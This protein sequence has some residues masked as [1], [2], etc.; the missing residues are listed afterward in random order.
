LGTSIPLELV[1]LAWHVIH[2]DWKPHGS[3]DNG[4]G[5]SSSVWRT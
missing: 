4:G 5:G 2:G 1:L 3:S